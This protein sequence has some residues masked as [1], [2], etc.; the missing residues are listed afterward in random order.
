MSS[1]L[2]VLKL[3]WGLRNVQ[4]A[5]VIKEK[6]REIG[7]SISFEEWYYEYSHYSSFQSNSLKAIFLAIHASF[8]SQLKILCT[9][10]DKYYNDISN[11]FKEP[12]G[13]KIEKYIA[14]F[15]KRFKHDKEFKEHAVQRKHIT[16]LRN[17]IMHNDSTINKQK[18][19]SEF[20]WIN[21]NSSL[22]LIHNSLEHDKI[23]K[24]E[25][26]SSLF[27][28]DYLNIIN[29]IFVVIFKEVLHLKK[30]Q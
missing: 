5:R 7:E 13:D 22:S 27:I 21:E 2:E 11:S 25:I 10:L 23:Y 14:Y 20:R 28:T 15:I 4:V 6:E 24:I 16:F 18:S 19:R 12:D 3:D 8:E 9:F 26:I 17:Q 29:K 1:D 30:A